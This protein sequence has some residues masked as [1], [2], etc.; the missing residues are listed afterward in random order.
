MPGPV[1]VSHFVHRANLDC[2]ASGESPR[3]LAAKRILADKFRAVGYKVALEESYPAASRRVD[4]AVTI[5]GSELRYAVE[6][7]DSAIT[8]QEMSRRTVAD[9]RGPGGFQS[10]YWVWTGGRANRLLTAPQGG[11]V[12]VTADVLHGILGNSEVCCLDVDE[13]ELWAVRLDTVVRPGRKY[14]DKIYPDVRLK[15]IHRIRRRR[16]GFALF[17]KPELAPL[18][19]FRSEERK[20]IVGEEDVIRLLEEIRGS[21]LLDDRDGPVFGSDFIGQLTKLAVRAFGWPRTLMLE[22]WVEKALRFAGVHDVENRIAVRR[23]CERIH[24]DGGKIRKPN[25]HFCP[26]PVPK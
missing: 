24:L 13:Q 8:T 16:V 2:P 9:T 19:E 14:P 11:E 26:G 6:V 1:V 25:M 17:G 7:Q 18:P 23:V 20:L 5:P 3:H 4:V 22:F 21:S 12:R 15:S 10:T